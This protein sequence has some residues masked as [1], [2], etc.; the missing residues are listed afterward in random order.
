ME[1]ID[2]VMAQMLTLT[3]ASDSTASGVQLLSCKDGDE[4]SSQVEGLP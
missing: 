4:R 1:V 2:R 3:L